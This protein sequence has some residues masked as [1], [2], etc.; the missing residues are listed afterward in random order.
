MG[1]IL[2]LL[3]LFGSGNIYN[4]QDTTRNILPSEEFEGIWIADSSDLTYEITFSKKVIYLKM[5]DRH[6]ESI[7]GS[8]K[9]LKN[10]KLIKQRKTNDSTDFPLIGMIENKDKLSLTY[11]EPNVK[12]GNIS[13]I[14]DSTRKKASWLLKQNEGFV[15]PNETKK[16]YEMPF[17]LTFRKK[18]D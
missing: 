1:K 5:I 16:K 2:L 4:L 10:N 11:S 13:F 17:E 6:V 12:T 15:L 3:S 14:L 9:I 8:I 7:L 18:E